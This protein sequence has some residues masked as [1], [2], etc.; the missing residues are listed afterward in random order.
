MAAVARGIAPYA[1]QLSTKH[2]KS[3]PETIDPPRSHPLE[4]RHRLC[5]MGGHPTSV[6]PAPQTPIPPPPTKRASNMTSANSKNRPST[7]PSPA[8]FGPWP[9]WRQQAVEALAGKAGHG[10]VRRH[11][12]GG[13]NDCGTSKAKLRR[14]R[15]RVR[16]DPNEW[17]VSCPHCVTCNKIVGG[18]Q[19]GELENSHPSRTSPSRLTH[20][21][22]NLQGGASACGLCTIPHPQ[23]RENPPVPLV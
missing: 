8:V 18:S 12:Q 2:Q 11:R 23:G 5:T 13:L 10:K 7:Q 9:G 14:P 3:R 19:D 1:Q 15:P 22:M 21:P 20:P 6:L 4:G 17:P 16:C